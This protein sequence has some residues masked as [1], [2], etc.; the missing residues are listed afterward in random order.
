[1]TRS[2]AARAVPLPPLASALACAL[3]LLGGGVAGCAGTELESAT[4]DVRSTIAAARENGAY[5]CAPRELALAETHVEFAERKIDRGDYFAARDEI[6]IADHN[7][8]EAHRLSPK[9]RCVGMV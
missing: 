9:D 6:Q 4:H 5:K 1:M 8:R 7:A 2:A 3:A